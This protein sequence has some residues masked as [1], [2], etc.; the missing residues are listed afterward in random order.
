MKSQKLGRST[1]VEIQNISDRGIWLLVGRREYF[2]PHEDFPWFT[3]ATV[4][5]ISNVDLIHGHHLIWP[6]LDVELE[7]ESLENLENYPLIYKRK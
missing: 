2:L 7:L 5:Q 3:N 6:D 4:K 1:L